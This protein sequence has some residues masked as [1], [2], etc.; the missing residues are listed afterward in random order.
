MF[1]LFAV[2]VGCGFSRKLVAPMSA[3][4]KICTQKKQRANSRRNH[5]NP[6]VGN[7]MSRLYLFMRKVYRKIVVINWLKLV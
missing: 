5:K 4:L 1:S 2:G 6:F 7:E 3:S